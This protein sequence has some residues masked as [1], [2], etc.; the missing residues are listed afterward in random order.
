MTFGQ[1]DASLGGV[2][3]VPGRHSENPKVDRSERDGI[4]T[5]WD[6]VY[7]VGED[8]ECEAWFMIH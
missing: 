4:F 1:S 8:F 3:I 6:F 5:G 7:Y 2:W